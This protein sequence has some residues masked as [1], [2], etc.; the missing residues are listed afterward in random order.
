VLNEAVDSSAWFTWL[1]FRARYDLPPEGGSHERAA[2]KAEA[3]S[4]Q[5]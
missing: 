3:T 2:L 5:R 1:D 4:V